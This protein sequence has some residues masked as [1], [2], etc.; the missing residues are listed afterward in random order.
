M[1][2]RNIQL[3]MRALEQIYFSYFAIL[4]GK[5]NFTAASKNLARYRSGSNFI[6]GYQN[7]YVAYPSMIMQ[8][9]LTL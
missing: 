6:L 8:I 1:H 3:S 9:V 2:K 7:N 5:N 4:H